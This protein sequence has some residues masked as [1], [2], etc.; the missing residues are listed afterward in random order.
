MK[1][2]SFLTGVLIGI[3]I[4]LAGALIVGYVMYERL[5]ASKNN[6][7][8]PQV[9]GGAPVQQ[10][11]L[12]IPDF[13]A[14]KT[15]ADMISALNKI[16]ALRPNDPMAY[17]QKASILNEMGAYEEALKNF[18]RALA[19]DPTNAQAYLN[20]SISRFMMGDYNGSIKDLNYA[21]QL[22]PQLAQAYYNRGVANVNVSQFNRAMA[23]FSKAKDL[24]LQA[25]DFASYTDSD[26]AVK[27]LAQYNAA[28]SAQ[29]VKGGKKRPGAK[30][31]GGASAPKQNPKELVSIKR[32]D[33]SIDRNKSSLTASLNTGGAQG[34]LEK[35]KQNAALNRQGD[36]PG[37]GDLGNYESAVRKTM[38]EGQGKA[39]DMPKNVLDYRGDARNKMA[40]GDFKGAASDLDKAIELSPND[41]NLYA[42]RAMAHA[43][44]R[45]SANAIK[46]YSKAIEMNPNNALA[47]QQRA[48][49]KALM[50]DNKGA[51]KDLEQ[52]QNLYNEQGNEKGAQ[53][54][55]NLANTIQGKTVETTKEDTEAQRLL[56]EG[57]NA[58]AQGN[59][60]KALEHFDA[61]IARQPNVPEL[62]YNRAITNNALGKSDAAEKDF[63]RAIQKGGGNMP[64]NYSGLAG[65][66]LQQ[67]KLDE[68]RKSAQKAISLNPDLAN[69]YKTL[70]MADA[71]DGRT[72]SALKY[73]NIALE[74]DPEDPTSL[75]TRGLLYAQSSDLK[76][77][78]PEKIGEYQENFTKAMEDFQKGKA[79]ADKQGNAALSGEFTKNIQQVQQI[80]DQLGQY[81]Q[82]AGGK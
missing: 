77:A 61:L 3:I 55:R 73:A 21:V 30:G 37:L 33:S 53:Q 22:N 70:A 15:P 54:A 16:I 8:Q 47:Y 35:F 31:T 68:A 76:N 32:D 34:V 49:Q 25:K 62:Y 38:A 82:S 7:A 6:P 58:Y 65:A 10:Q 46:D 5:A 74:K 20:R 67:G 27:M 69:P 26:K 64:D 11:G 40:A 79:L 42:E 66:Q 43:Q 48:Q 72:E 12:Q 41:S 81:Q 50:G 75:Y 19:L 45:D 36:M 24:F 14:A 71:Q 39:K 78:K 59:Y 23:D 56:K 57:T 18:D 63:Q 29:P 44:Q 2:S 13:K 52:A 28:A 4:C 60:D 17:L 9:A 51:L 1:K 80:L